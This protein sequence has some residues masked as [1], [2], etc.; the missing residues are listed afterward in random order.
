MPKSDGLA[1]E[2][3]KITYRDARGADF[4][5]L[6]IPALFPSPALCRDNGAMI[7]YAGWHALRA[8]RVTRLDVSA[9]PNLDAFPAG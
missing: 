1:V 3:L 5:A 4:C 7:A 8:G 2:G 6:D 9:I